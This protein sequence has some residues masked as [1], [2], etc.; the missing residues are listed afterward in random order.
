MNRDERIRQEARESLARIVQMFEA[1]HTPGE[2]IR[3]L[4]REIDALKTRLPR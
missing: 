2:T 3:V 4:L 1:A